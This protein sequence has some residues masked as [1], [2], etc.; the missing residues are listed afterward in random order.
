MQCGRGFD[1][2]TGRR[3]SVV[4]GSAWGERVNW[5]ETPAK[6]C[7]TCRARRDRLQGVGLA[8]LILT[9]ASCG[10]LTVITVPALIVLVI[11]SNRPCQLCRDLAR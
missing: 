9:A 11:L 8:A 1:G 7:P 10:L 2:D 5:L 4:G 6:E 3:V